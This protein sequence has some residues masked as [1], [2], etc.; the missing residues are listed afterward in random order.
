MSKKDR[1]AA[2][3]HDAA[4]DLVGRKLYGDMWISEPSK[5]EWRIAKR[6]GYTTW[7]INRRASFPVASLP[8]DPKRAADHAKACFRFWT[9]IIQYD[10]VCLWLDQQHVARTSTTFELTEFKAWFE[11]KFGETFLSPT[12]KRRSAVKTALQELGKPGRG[13]KVGWKKFC[14][15]VCEICQQ[16]WKLR[17]IQRDVHELLPE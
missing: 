3:D 8:V 16:T 5:P 15:R 14:R 4:I 9:S 11:K 2:I 10:Q 1:D 12:D 6:Y 13:A 7:H 17:T